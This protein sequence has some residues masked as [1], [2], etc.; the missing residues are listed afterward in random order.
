MKSWSKQ[1]IKRVCL[2]RQAESARSAKYKPGYYSDLLLLKIF[3]VKPLNL[4][5]SGTR[6]Y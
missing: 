1:S 5:T 4:M 3:D 6:L 2:S